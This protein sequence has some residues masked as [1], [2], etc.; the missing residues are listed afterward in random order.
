MSV[1][2]AEV[3]IHNHGSDIPFKIDLSEVISFSLHVEPARVH[4]RQIHLKSAP[5]L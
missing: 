5:W 1:V 3:T 4:M 2:L